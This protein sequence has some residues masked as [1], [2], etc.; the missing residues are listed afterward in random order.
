MVVAPEKVDADKAAAVMKLQR[1]QR[2]KSSRKV[3]KARKDELEAAIPEPE[4]EDDDFMWKCR[5]GLVCLVLKGAP[6]FDVD[7]HSS[8]D[9][10]F[11][12][13]E[14]MDSK[15]RS[16]HNKGKSAISKS[17]KGVS[18]TWYSLDKVS[19]FRGREHIKPVKRSATATN[20][21]AYVDCCNTLCVTDGGKD[22]FVTACGLSAPLRS[23]TRACVRR[24]DGKLHDPAGVPITGG[25]DHE[26]WDELPEPKF[27]GY[28]EAI[29]QVIDGFEA[30]TEE[31]VE[32]VAGAW[33]PKGDDPKLFYDDVAAVKEMAVG[34]VGIDDALQD[35][36]ADAKERAR[37]EAEEARLKAIEDAARAEE[38]ARQAA[39]VAEAQAFLDANP[40]QA[41]ILE[42]DPE[43]AALGVV[44]KAE[45]MREAMGLNDAPAA[46]EAKGEMS[47]DDVIASMAGQM[48]GDASATAVELNPC[49]QI[50][51]APLFDSEEVTRKARAI[52][53]EAFKR[54][55]TDGS[56]QID[57]D[58][59]FEMCL[60]VGQV[61]PQGATTPEKLEYLEKQW[62][63]ADVDGDGTVDFDEFVEFYVCTL[64]ALAAEEAARHAFSRYDVDDS[65]TLEKH[66]LVQALFELDMVP[67]HDAHEKRVY[68]E[69]QFAIADTNGDGVVDFAEFIAFYTTALHD[70]RKSELVHERR[71]KTK[72]AREKR[73]ERALKYVQAQALEEAIKAKQL[74][75]LSAKWLLAR[76]GYKG[77]DVERRGVTKTKWA[78]TGEPT[79]LPPRQVLEKEDPAA[80][81]T[82]EVFQAGLAAFAE[83]CE[84]NSAGSAGIE[85]VPIILASHVWE[86]EEH[87]DPAGVVLGRV[88]ANLAR[89]MQT[90]Q[91]WGFDDVGVF[92]DW[93][94]LYQSVPSGAFTRTPEQE[95]HMALARQE[96]PIWIAHKM[97][98]VY[99]LPDQQVTP[100]PAE[101][102]WL[103]FTTSLCALFKDSPPTKPFKVKH[104]QLVPFWAKIVDLSDEDVANDTSGIN[105]QA[106]T[107]KRRPPLS[108]PHFIEQ[109]KPKWF[110]AAD[111]RER[112][113]LEHNYRFAIEDG[114]N[115]LE[116][117]S[118]GKLNW[119]DD[120]VAEL[121]SC[122]QE[123]SMPHVTELDLSWNDMRDGKGLEAIGF[124][125]SIGA[126]HSLQ[127]LNLINCTAIKTL[128]ESIGE[129]LE[130][131]VILL[132]GCVQLRALPQAMTKLASLKTL[133]II[134]CHLLFDEE[135]K[136]M[137][138]SCAVVR[139]PKEATPR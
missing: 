12:I 110:S 84:A 46:A 39:I 136:H 120:D 24:A 122:F 27:K 20:V 55:D 1:L 31:R 66:E 74:A 113:T 44:E 94:C 97:T 5:C 83:L 107:P 61:A 92:L 87:A 32:E 34:L 65:N 78:K 118:Y 95:K 37:K 42:K 88:A 103:F 105:P 28:P 63:L 128:P 49:L 85:A 8:V 6:L 45:R 112:T 16:M 29:Q 9:S 76:A 102:G 132:D 30:Y 64:E 99:H 2:G 124:A 13:A 26:A 40:M 68:L 51:Q 134:N 114:F 18:K 101:H 58:E 104:D 36:I 59:L 11:P 17:G 72:I 121:A 4:L 10:V 57:K 126:L 123:V 139:Q 129:L 111:E 93:P 86:T 127:R 25:A 79:P 116:R 54:Y 80:Y 119:T 43:T 47:L 89:Q 23:F 131:Q 96:L 98:T 82:A 71:R 73:R 48:V 52:A 19:V 41:A 67:G 75:P 35:F 77:T 62:A 125:I 138:S 33:G 22:M 91:A 135:L 70:S 50:I 109:L 56:G 117:L 130:L 133:N 15:G 90:Y 38:E 60:T 106:G 115:S 3:A 7:C 14:Y 81:L 53:D 69:D 100:P 137:P 108:A 21:R